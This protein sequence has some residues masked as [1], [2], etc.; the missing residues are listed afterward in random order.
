MLLNVVQVPQA[1]SGG[2]AGTI[3]TDSHGSAGTLSSASLSP[4][5]Y[6]I[7]LFS[8]DGKGWS[9]Q[10]SAIP[11][12]TL[13][14]YAASGTG[15]RFAVA[16]VSLDYKLSNA[17]PPLGDTVFAVTVLPANRLAFTALPAGGG[18]GT[19]AGT[20]QG[21]TGPQ[22]YLVQVYRWQNTT[23]WTPA[24]SATPTETG[25]WAV[26]GVD[27][28]LQYAA[29]LV[30]SAIT[31]PAGFLPAGPG[32]LAVLYSAPVT[33]A[34]TSIPPST[35]GPIAGALLGFNGVPPGTQVLVFALDSVQVEN[36]GTVDRVQSWA[37]AELNAN[38]IWT[39]G[40]ISFGAQWGLVLADAAYSY[41]DGDP[42]PRVGGLVIATSVISPSVL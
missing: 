30:R 8:F 7:A 27:S 37:K 23:A 29:V 38:G 41:G 25:T 16:L 22:N 21:L 33:I 2:I 32:V 12:S 1:S 34:A 11:V 5:S 26:G 42:F 20:V 17:L 40:H 15:Q 4:S 18:V 6:A 35:G 36:L 10:T 9:G 3:A 19:V 28:S 13:W 39:L 31:A 14:N 24:G